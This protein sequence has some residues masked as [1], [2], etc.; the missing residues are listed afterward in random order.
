VVYQLELLSEWKIHNVFHA[1]LLSPYMET[2]AHGPNYVHPPPDLVRG[3]QEYEVERIINHRHTGQ[4]KKLQYLIKWKGYLESDNTWEPT[5]HLHAPQLIKEY[6]KHIGKSSIKT[7][8]GQRSRVITPFSNWLGK[9]SNNCSSLHPPHMPN[10]IGLTA[11]LRLVLSMI[12]SRKGKSVTQKGKRVQPQHTQEFT[13]F[14][15]KTLT[16]APISPIKSWTSTTSQ[17]K[18]RTIPSITPPSFASPSPR[19][20]SCHPLQLARQ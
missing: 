11:H 8:L 5:S 3:E 1:S 16:A 13:P 15:A 7:I 9:L 17:M 2:N 4:G 14:T 6:Q 19:S 18:S 12:L 10:S 20:L